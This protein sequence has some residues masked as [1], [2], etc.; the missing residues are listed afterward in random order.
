MRPSA[1]SIRK[2][3]QHWPR[4]ITL[5]W[6]QVRPWSEDVSG[7][8]AFAMEDYD[9]GKYSLGI[10]YSPDDGDWEMLKGVEVG[11][12]ERI[13]SLSVNATGPYMVRFQVKSISPTPLGICTSMRLSSTGG[14]AGVTT[15]SEGLL[16]ESSNS[17]SSICK[18]LLFI[19]FN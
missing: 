15:S 12:K 13:D 1:R 5:S 3:S 9:M 7:K 10:V 18:T 19:F 17:P 8:M 16:H 14:G 4:K 6:D 11:P 2:G